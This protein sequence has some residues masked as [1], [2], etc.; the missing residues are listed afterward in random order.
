VTKL[1][2]ES[3]ASLSIDETNQLYDQYE[4]KSVLQS[5]CGLALDQRPGVGLGW[6]HHIVGRKLVLAVVD[7]DGFACALFR[8]IIDKISLAPLED[9]YLAASLRYLSPELGEWNGVLSGGKDCKRHQATTI[10]SLLDELVFRLNV[11]L[12]F[13]RSS[14]S[15]SPPAISVVAGS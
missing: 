10:S 9:S 4:R 11:D 7:A 8:R 12:H 15:S 6:C 1:L 13:S 3:H 2:P 14:A 5:F